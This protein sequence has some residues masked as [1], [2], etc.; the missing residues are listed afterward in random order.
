LQERRLSDGEGIQTIR[1][2]VSNLKKAGKSE[3]GR[4]PLS[5]E[6]LEKYKLKLN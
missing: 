4:V 3:V 1:P 5:L 6:R 2:L